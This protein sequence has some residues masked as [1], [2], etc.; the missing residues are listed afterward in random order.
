MR[1]RVFDKIGTISFP[2]HAKPVILFLAPLNTIF[3]AFKIQALC[4]MSSQSF[5]SHIPLTFD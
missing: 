1:N 2:P 3:F 5:L 4:F